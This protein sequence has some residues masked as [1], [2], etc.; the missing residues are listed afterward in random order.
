MGSVTVLLQYAVNKGVNIETADF[1]NE[2]KSLYYILYPDDDVS[3]ASGICMTSNIHVK[4]IT[5]K[6]FE[7]V[8]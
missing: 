3:R 4:R 7:W 2:K 8:V 6:V 5:R 1:P